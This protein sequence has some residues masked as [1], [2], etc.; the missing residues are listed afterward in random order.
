MT[1]AAIDRAPPLPLPCSLAEN[2]GALSSRP[3]VSW[4]RGSGGIWQA[5]QCLAAI[6]GALGGKSAP[7]RVRGLKG[8]RGEKERGQSCAAG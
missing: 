4:D 8:V 7:A 1:P 6:L 2:L 5:F 3:G